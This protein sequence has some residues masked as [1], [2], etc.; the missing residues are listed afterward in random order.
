M[1]QRLCQ[2]YSLITKQYGSQYGYQRFQ[3]IPFQ[4]VSACLIPNTW[5]RIHFSSRLEMSVTGRRHFKTDG[6]NSLKYDLSQIDRLKLYTRVYVNILEN[7]SWYGVTL[8]QVTRS[9]SKDAFIIRY[10]GYMTSSP[11]VGPSLQKPWIRPC[12][13]D[14]VLNRIP[15]R[16]GSHISATKNCANAWV[17]SWSPISVFSTAMQLP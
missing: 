10:S 14:N 16:N 15:G 17:Q 1:W 6:L 12:I 11:G 5:F 2:E 9:S 3:L 7:S 4:S 8:H 13:I